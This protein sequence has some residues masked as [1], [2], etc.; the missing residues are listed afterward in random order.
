MGFGRVG[1]E[2]YRLAAAAGD[3]DVVVVADIA[4]AEV[5]HYLLGR[6]GTQYGLDGNWL[7]HGKSRTRMLRISDPHEVP[8]DAFSVDIVLEATG[9]YRSPSLLQEHIANGAGRVLLTTLPDEPVDRLVIVGVNE[10]E[11]EPGDRIICAGSQTTTAFA[12]AVQTLDAAFG[13]EHASMTTVHAFTSDQPAQDYP[14]EDARRSRSAAKNIIPNS[15]AT[16]YWTGVVLPHLAGKLAGDLGIDPK[17]LDEAYD[18]DFY[19][20]N[21]L[22]AGVYFDRET[23][24]VDRTIAHPLF[25]EPYEGWLPIARSRISLED[26]VAKMPVSEAAKRD[27]YAVLLVNADF[28]EGHLRH[29]SNIRPNRLFTADQQLILYRVGHLTDDRMNQTTEAVI[30]ILRR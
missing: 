12:L 14:A 20:R 25:P 19:K 9:R 24:G 11:A 13:V 21:K 8:W 26:A 29:E 22:T 28:L 6:R 10:P 2:F 27:P 30:Q 15:S 23:F 5:L 18:F 17:R 16:P 7:T 3:V 4:K 1:R